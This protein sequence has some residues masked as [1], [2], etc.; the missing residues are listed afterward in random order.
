MG[1][2]CAA[3]LLSFAALLAGTARA[4]TP[5]AAL[6]ASPDVTLDLSGVVLDDGDLGADDLVGPVVPLDLGPVPIHADLDA[7]HDLGDGARLLSLDVTTDLPGIGAAGPADV[8]RWDGAAYS[9]E[10]DAAAAGVPA[11]ARVDAISRAENGDLILSFDVTVDLGG[12]VAAD[13]DLVRYDAGVGT[14]SLYFDGSDAGL[15]TALDLDAAERLANGHLLLSF[16]LSGSVGGV[17]FDDEDVLEYDPTA[18][19]WE[20]SYDGSAEDSGWPGA[21]VD[22]ISILPIGDADGDGL[23]DSND[24]CRARFNPSQGDKDMDGFGDVCDCD[25]DNDRLCNIDDFTA[26]LADFTTQIDG[27]AGTDMNG[28]GQVGIADFDL[29]LAGFQAGEPGP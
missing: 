27:G 20:T 16:D 23:P 13:E 19:S 29:F 17:A 15:S 4:A 26:F 22:A 25:F 1:H 9:L 28:D 18:G 6:D 3:V 5:L 10:F 24:N 12:V 7:A 11:G 2:F 14:F 8:A 21:D